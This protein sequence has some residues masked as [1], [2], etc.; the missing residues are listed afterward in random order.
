MQQGQQDN[1]EVAQE[2]EPAVRCGEIKNLVGKGTGRSTGGII[3]EEGII[4][5]GECG[6]VGI[7]YDEVVSD[8]SDNSKN[9]K[10]CDRIITVKPTEHLL[11]KVMFSV[12]KTVSRG[13]TCGQ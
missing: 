7:A 1:Q 3:G 6:D 13:K 9:E 12:N 2:V 11:P 10:E 5:A 4:V 8:E